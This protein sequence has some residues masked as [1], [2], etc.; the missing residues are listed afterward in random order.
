MTKFFRNLW[1]D[2]AGQDLAEYTMLIVLIAIACIG[3]V[4]ALGGGVEAGLN[5]AAGSLFT[6]GGSGGSGGS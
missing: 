1:Q 6:G 5:D 2:E 3:A 4:T